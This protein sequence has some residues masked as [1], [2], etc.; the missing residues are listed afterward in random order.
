MGITQFI[1]PQYFERDIEKS[2]VAKVTYV[3]FLLESMIFMLEP[4]SM[5]VAEVILVSPSEPES[6]PSWR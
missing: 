5:V 2:R 3:M 6:E 1:I 4:A